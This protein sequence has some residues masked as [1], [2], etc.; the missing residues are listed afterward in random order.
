M[1]RTSGILR[2]STN[3]TPKTNKQI[4]KTKESNT[5][6]KKR[7]GD[8]KL[9]ERKHKKL[10]ESAKRNKKAEVVSDTHD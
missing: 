5:G 1:P 10:R 7:F 2:F 3:A 9:E 8:S 6:N 4:N